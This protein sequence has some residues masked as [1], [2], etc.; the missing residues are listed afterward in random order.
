MQGLRKWKLVEEMMRHNADLV[1]FQECDHFH[2][3]FAPVMSIL[4]YEGKSARINLG[5]GGFSLDF[6]GL[7]ART[8][9]PHGGA[10]YVQ[11]SR[12]NRVGLR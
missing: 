2:D 8:E 9:G 12:R 6:V 7:S 5:E 10:S 4:G 1:T 3:F 11:M